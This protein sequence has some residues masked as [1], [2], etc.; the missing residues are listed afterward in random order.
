M[1]FE[2]GN[3]YK[4]RGGWTA[5]IVAKMKSRTPLVVVHST[6]LNNLGGQECET[7]NSDGTFFTELDHSKYDLVELI[8]EME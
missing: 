4:T 8:R 3:L 6:N 1:N 2:I 7:H 5:R